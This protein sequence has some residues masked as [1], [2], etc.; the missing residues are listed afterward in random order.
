MIA[1]VTGIVVTSQA[2]N[3]PSPPAGDRI[4]KPPNPERRTRQPMKKD[5]G[6]EEPSDAGT[7]P[8]RPEEGHRAPV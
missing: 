2:T 3:P 6:M 1:A 4:T 5:E 8:R 7:I